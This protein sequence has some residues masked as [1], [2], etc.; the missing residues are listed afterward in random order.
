MK[1]PP[2][3]GGGDRIILSFIEGWLCRSG[4]GGG[5]VVVVAVFGS[6]G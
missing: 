4:R 5:V 2:H 6:R 1:R 3:R